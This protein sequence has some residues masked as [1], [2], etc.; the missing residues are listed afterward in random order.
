MSDFDGKV[1]VITGVGRPQGVGRAAALRYAA[2]GAKLVLADLGSRDDAIGDIEGTSPDLQAIATEV[3]DA[4]GDAIAIATD[5]S[6]EDD[7]K[8]LIAKTVDKYGR[9]DAMVANAAILAGK[10]DP[11]DISLATF[12][13][14]QEVNLAGVFLCLRESVRQMLIQGNGGSIVTIGSR[15]SRR[16]DANISA[17]SASKFGVLGLTQSFAMAYAK[18]RIRINCVC[19]GAVDTEM[20]VRQTKDFASR[21]GIDIETAKKEMGNLIP[22]GRLT[23]GEDVAKAIMW[24]TSDETSHVTG[25][26]FNVNGGSWMN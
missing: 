10:G 23:T 25:Q 24:F 17:Y 18:D 8:R 9:I 13:R 16:G 14:I 7:V 19:P 26:A 4:G 11:I 12:M 1:V 5:V 21:E 22:L 6:N 20:Y 3:A 2:K 15:A